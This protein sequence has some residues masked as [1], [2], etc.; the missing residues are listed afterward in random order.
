MAAVL[1][2]I[3]VF[4]VFSGQTLAN[5]EPTWESLD[6][7]P[8][9]AWYDEAKFG[10]FIHWGVFS[11]PSF[12]SEWFWNYWNHRYP[13]YVDFMQ[14]NYPPGFTYQD[15]AP[16]FTAEFF[17]PNVWSE[18]LSASGAKYVVL[19]TKHHEGKH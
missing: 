11:V 16:L 5:Y 7:R 18:V 12:G 9:P 2:C 19:T 13:A 6:A 15:F 1:L 10:I 8:L 4:L 17:D 3:C 14:R